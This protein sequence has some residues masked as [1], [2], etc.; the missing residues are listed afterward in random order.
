MKFNKENCKVLHLWKNNP[1]HQYMLGENQ[2]E[3]SFAEK[4]MGVLVDIR[5]NISQQCA[6]DNG[7]QPQQCHDLL[8][9]WGPLNH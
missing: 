4:D 6:L 2:L 7:F 3:S 5:L 9:M 1:R 8:N